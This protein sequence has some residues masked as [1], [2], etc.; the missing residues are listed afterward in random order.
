MKML[1]LRHVRASVLKEVS[2]RSH[3]PNEAA[4]TDDKPAC[5]DSVS[6]QAQLPVQFSEE[7]TS[8]S[9]A[10]P[11]HGS[12]EASILFK[13]SYVRAAVTQICKFEFLWVAEVK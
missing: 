12:L 4:T 5:R 6:N 10:K 7:E 3:L 8:E 1:A 9:K 2:R 11:N 13:Q